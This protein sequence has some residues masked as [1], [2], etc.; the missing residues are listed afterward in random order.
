MSET[1]MSTISAEYLKA[2]YEYSPE[3]AAREGLHEY[4]GR[5]GDPSGAARKAR[6]CELRAFE[7]RFAQV[8]PTG[9]DGMERFEHELLTANV[10]YEL[11]E[12]ESFRAHEWNPMVYLFPTSVSGYAGRSYAPLEDRVGAMIRHLGAVPEYLDAA[13]PNLRAELPRDTLEVSLTAFEGQAAYVRGEL[14]QAVRNVEDRGLLREFEAVS[15]LAAVAFDDFTARLRERL[16]SAGGEFAIGRESYE[17]MLRSGEMIGLPL[18]RV[19]EVGEANLLRN[20]ELLRE[21]AR[22]INPGASPAETVR[23]IGKEHPAAAELIP[24]TAR[25]LEEI[26][27][28]LIEADI[29][30]VPSEVRCQVKETPPYMRWAF[31]LMDSPGPFEQTATE[32]YY[33]IT[34]VEPDWTP[35]QQEEWLSRFSYHTLKDVSV[36]EAYPG[37]YLHWLHM[38]HAPSDASKTLISYAFVEGWAHYSEQMMIESGYGNHDPKLL[39]AQLS[40]ALLRNCRY[41]VSI[42]MHTQGMSVDDATRFLMEQGY[43]DELPARREAVRGT[44]DPG[45]LNYTLGKLQFLKLREDYEREQGFSFSLREFHDRC[46]AYG[47]PPVPLLRKQLLRDG[48]GDIL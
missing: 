4:D 28:F 18:E 33:Y 17:Q 9:L 1:T 44:F 3:R 36:H 6:A 7:E 24:E 41:I 38:K 16:A 15:E 29:V 2:M 8:D 10:S 13:W 19:L 34:P 5:M 27:T 21:T 26:R 23:Q 31:A 40:E 11:W 35:E 42:L 25:L 43:M 12:L 32:A 45:Y 37:H 14:R 22:R 39:L 47:A 46:L 20:Q 48:A 30:S